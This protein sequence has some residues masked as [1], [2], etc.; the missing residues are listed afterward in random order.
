MCVCVCEF[1][2]V[3]VCVCDHVMPSCSTFYTFAQTRLFIGI[4]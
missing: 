3:C 4:I 1:A 2:C